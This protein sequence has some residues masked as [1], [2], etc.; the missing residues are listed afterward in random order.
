MVLLI[1]RSLSARSRRQMKVADL[2]QADARQSQF[3]PSPNELRMLRTTPLGLAR[4]VSGSA[5]TH[6][7]FAISLSFLILGSL[8]SQTRKYG[9]IFG[10][11]TAAIR[12]LQQTFERQECS[13]K[14][15]ETLGQANGSFARP[16]ASNRTGRRRPSFCRSAKRPNFSHSRIYGRYLQA[17]VGSHFRDGTASR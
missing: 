17:D 4:C 14:L 8:T 11:W 15:H 16:S 6:G 3:N 1:D 5:N 10:E 2:Q 12:R 13:R 9:R 7:I